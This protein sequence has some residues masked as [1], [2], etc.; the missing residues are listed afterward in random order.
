M[1]KW[2]EVQPI[3]MLGIRTTCKED[4]KATLTEMVYGK[5]IRS[6]EEFSTQV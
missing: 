3:I 5:Q 6:P 4:L 1:D 2:V